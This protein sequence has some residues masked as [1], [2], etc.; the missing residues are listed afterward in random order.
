MKGYE[1]RTRDLLFDESKRWPALDAIGGVPNFTR[2]CAWLALL[3]TGF[4]MRNIRELRWSDIDFD[5][6]R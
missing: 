5:E 3:F 6:R 1:A 4:R 2:R